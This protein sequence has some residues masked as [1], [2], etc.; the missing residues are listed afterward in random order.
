MQ[1]QS[2]KTMI[3]W[4]PIG[5]QTSCIHQHSSRG[6]RSTLSS[7]DKNLSVL[8]WKVSWYWESSSSPNVFSVQRTQAVPQ[9]MPYSPRSKI[10]G[11]FLYLLPVTPETDSN[12]NWETEEAYLW[13][14]SILQKGFFLSLKY[15][16]HFKHPVDQKFWVEWR[17]FW[18]PSY[19]FTKAWVRSYKKTQVSW[20]LSKQSCREKPRTRVKV[21]HKCHQPRPDKI[22]SFAL[23]LLYPC[24]FCF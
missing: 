17:F 5:A 19:H 6:C 22:H 4:S 21:F 13:G 15:Y 10:K 20:Q 8:M 23:R 12:Q 2:L 1:S 3:L 24:S 9:T 7:Q 11:K 14:I 18:Y 16:L